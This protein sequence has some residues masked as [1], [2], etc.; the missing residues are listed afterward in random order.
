M[1]VGSVLQLPKRV[2]ES[3]LGV[4]VYSNKLHG[5]SDCGDIARSGVPTRV[6]LDVG[7]NVGAVARE[8]LRNFPEAQV[9]C[10]EPVPATFERL[11]TNLRGFG[12]ATLHREAVGTKVGS[13]KMFVGSNS[14]TNSLVKSSSH[15]NEIEVPVTTIDAFCAQ[16]GIQA[17]DLLKIDAEGFDMEVLK[18]GIGLLSAG[19]VTFILIEATP[20]RSVQQHVWLGEVQNFL[21]PF[22]FQLYGLY[23]QM[24]AW[25]GRPMVQFANALFRRQ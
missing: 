21:E 6:V 9:H 19:R 24:L 3:L 13:T 11:K 14:F 12:R 8:Y 22:G 20:N 1:S 7:A 10:F 25:D 5:H 16:H 18:G 15:S 2:F 4:R 17:I 23:D